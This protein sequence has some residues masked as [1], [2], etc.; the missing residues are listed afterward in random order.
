[1]VDANQGTQLASNEIY[2]KELLEVFNKNPNS[3]DLDDTTKILLGQIR[4]VQQEVTGLSQQIEQLNN[5][6]RER[7]EKANNLV[8]NLI[9][10]KGENQ[11]HLNTLLKIRK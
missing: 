10:K 11:G 4:E 7:R 5:E 8:E 2:L 9:L 1:M 3:A 6:I